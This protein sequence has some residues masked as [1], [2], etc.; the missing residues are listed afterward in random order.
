MTY[1]KYEAYLWDQTVA[2]VRH[3]TAGED[4]AYRNLD[5]I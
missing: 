5:P 2:D 4:G 1:F 3:I